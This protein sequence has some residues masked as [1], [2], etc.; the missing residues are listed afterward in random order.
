[1]RVSVH[2]FVYSGENEEK[3][4]NRSNEKGKQKKRRKKC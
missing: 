1:M 3:C 2:A 4:K